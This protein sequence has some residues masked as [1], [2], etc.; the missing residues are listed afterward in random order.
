MAEILAYVR[1]ITFTNLLGN[2]T[3]A[4][5]SLFRKNGYTPTFFE[6]VVGAAVAPFALVLILLAKFDRQVGIEKLSPWRRRR[7]GSLAEPGL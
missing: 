5:F 4:F 3:D 7:E 2:T 6:G 1:F